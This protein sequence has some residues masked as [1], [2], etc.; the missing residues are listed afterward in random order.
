MC[1]ITFILYTSYTKLT[2]MDSDFCIEYI[3]YTNTEKIFILVYLL[4]SIIS[5]FCKL[6]IRHEKGAII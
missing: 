4:P 1:F 3:F 6:Q 5:L 2:I